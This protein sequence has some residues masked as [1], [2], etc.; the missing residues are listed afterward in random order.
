[1]LFDVSHELAGD[2]GTDVSMG[3][4]NKIDPVAVDG[5]VAAQTTLKSTSNR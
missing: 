5:R 2:R 3:G 1:M 4:I